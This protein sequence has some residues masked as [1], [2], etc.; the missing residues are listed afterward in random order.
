MLLLVMAQLGKVLG[1]D[2]TTRFDMPELAGM[3]YGIVSW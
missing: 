1:F 2:V 3:G